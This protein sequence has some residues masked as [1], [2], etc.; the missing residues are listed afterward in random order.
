MKSLIKKLIRYDM[1]YD[2][3]KD[4]IIYEFYKKTYAQIANSIYAN[5][6]Q[7][8]FVIG[9]TGTDG[10]TTTANILHHLIQNNLGDCC[11]ISTAL[12]KI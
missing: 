5:P 4:S 6:S 9:I 1:R 10:K 7:D 12:I 8:M 11:M 3:L 2:I